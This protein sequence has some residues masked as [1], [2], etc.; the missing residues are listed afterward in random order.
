MLESSVLPR[1]HPMRLRIAKPFDDPNY[2]FELKYD[3][4]RA[5]AY[6]EEY[7]ILSVTLHWPSPFG[8]TIAAAWASALAVARIICAHQC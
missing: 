8:N 6:V 2:I 4:F 7:G 3:G 5:L 1:I